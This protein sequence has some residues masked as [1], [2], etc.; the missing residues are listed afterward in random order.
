MG[1]EDDGQL[2]GKCEVKYM[3][4]GSLAGTPMLRNR[5][6]AVIIWVFPLF[7]AREVSSLNNK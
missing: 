4:F 5:F 3:L 6:S 1:I 7:E 2:C